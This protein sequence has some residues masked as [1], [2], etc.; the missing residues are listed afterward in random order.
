MMGREK[1]PAHL[2]GVMDIRSRAFLKSVLFPEFCEMNRQA[3][4]EHKDFLFFLRGLSALRGE[5][6]R[7][8]PNEGCLT[9]L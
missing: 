3:R 1:H 5:K 7:I 2:L 4:K 8:S 6:D 9:G